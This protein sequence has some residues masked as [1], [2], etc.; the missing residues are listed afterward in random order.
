MDLTDRGVEGREPPKPLDVFLTT[1][2]GIYRVGETVYATAL[3]RDATA[4]AVAGR[5]AD[6]D[7]H[8]PRRQGAQPH[9]ARRPGPRR[10]RHAGRASGQR[11]AR[12]LADRRLRRREGRAARRDHLP[13]RG[14][15]AGAPR[16]R[17]RHD[18]DGASIRPRRPT[19]SID[20]RFL[21]GAPAAN[22][23]VEGETVLKPARELAAYPGYVFGLA[24]RDL[25]RDDRAVL[26][27]HDRRGRPRRR[28]RSRCRT[29]RRSSLPLDGRR[30]MCACSIRAARRSSAPSTL[31]VL[32]AS[33]PR[34]HPA[35][36]RRR[37]R[38]RTA[39]PPSR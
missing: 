37:G 8:P 27:R 11:H 31:P 9:R 15:R 22:L 18:R 39:R 19:L 7:R 33:G 4:I 12:H 3:V 36:L 16:L 1:E 17:H 14:F 38:P 2:R 34:R 26:R 32:D 35:A 29:P 24:G 13:G 10:H 28:S 5:A 21:Y 20:A 30:S 23:N 6:R 25:R